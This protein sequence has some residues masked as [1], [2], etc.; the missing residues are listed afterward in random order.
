MEENSINYMCATFEA[1]WQCVYLEK[2]NIVD[3]IMST[4]GDFVV[5]GAKKLCFNVNFRDETFQLCHR[6]ID[7]MSDDENPLLKHEL[8]KWPL[9]SSLLGNDCMKRA[10]NV[11]FETCFNN[12]FPKLVV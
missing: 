9:T 12:F 10:P 4:D 8:H 1:E 6:T 3:A 2:H 5:L 7:A 11:G